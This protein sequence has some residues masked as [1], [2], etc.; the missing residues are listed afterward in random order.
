MESIDMPDS[1][2]SWDNLFRNLPL[3]AMPEEGYR[4]GLREQVLAE[5]D[6]QS[7]SSPPI[8]IVNQTRKMLT[9]YYIPYWTA[10]TLLICLV[11]IVQPDSSKVAA[12]DVVA[13]IVNARTAQWDLFIKSDSGDD[14]QVKIFLAAGK[15]RLEFNGW[16]AIADH[17]QGQCMSLFSNEKLA[18]TGS[19]AQLGDNVLKLDQFEQ[20]RRELRI[21]MEDPEHN[22]E[23]LGLK[24]IDGQELVG[25][26]FKSKSLPTKIWADA[27]T[28][29]PILIEI[30]AENN[31]LVLKNHEF[32]IDLDPLL[33]SLEVPAGYRILNEDSPITGGS[34]QDFIR[35][36]EMYAKSANGEFPT[37]LDEQGL[38]E[39]NLQYLNHSIKHDISAEKPR[40]QAEQRADQLLVIQG[41][42]FP[43]GLA[44]DEKWDAHYGGTGV[45]LGTPDRPIFWYKPKT[46]APYRVI[47]ADL[48][49]RDEVEPPNLSKLN[50]VTSK[51]AKPKQ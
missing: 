17:T 3:D 32:N 34:E 19:V 48:T 45:R 39:A 37:R 44:A 7:R 14:Q 11:W 47:Y 22:V 8:V 20:M 23:N 36:L 40:S 13:H 46:S 29:F 31:Q 51:L 4:R 33:F 21:A 15:Q 41:A 9:K 35:S 25:F 5:F 18:I 24:I 2:K 10:A 42:T 6:N 12:Q 27:E 38:A 30:V 1:N 26:K 50:G 28:A 43:T 49:V 16:V